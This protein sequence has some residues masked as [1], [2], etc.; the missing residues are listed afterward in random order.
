MSQEKETWKA[1]HETLLAELEFRAGSKP[2]SIEPD[3]LDD[4]ADHLADVIVANFELV[5]RPK[6]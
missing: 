4:F 3:R 5:P 1:V 2:L 6:A